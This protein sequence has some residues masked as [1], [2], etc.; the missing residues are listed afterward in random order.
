MV[1]LYQVADGKVESVQ[2]FPFANE[3][4]DMK[5]FIKDN[6]R[7]L[8]EIKI[9]ADEATPP[10]KSKRSDLLAVDKDGNIVILELKNSKVTS[11]VLSQVLQYRTY[12][13]KSVDTVKNFWND[14][15]AKHQSEIQPG[16]EW[17]SYDPKVIIVA[18][19]F[20]ED[21]LEVA[22]SNKL[23]IDFVEMRR[24]KRA[25][26]VF[27]TVDVKEIEEF[28]TTPTPGRKSEE[29]DWDHYQKMFG[30][31][32]VDLAKYYV[33]KI[34]QI[35]Q[36]KGWKLETHHKK[37]YVP[38][39]YESRNPFY[40]EQY[41]VGKI[42]IGVNLKDPMED[43]SSET[44]LK[45]GWNKNW[46]HWYIETDSKDLDINRISGILQKAYDITARV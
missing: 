3:I 45:W 12:W 38:F 26:S 30:T 5:R 1:D 18:S 7:L 20:D 8:G 25:D 43:P 40:L 15:A 19:S 21:L 28:A 14:Y 42:V 35:S 13:M 36:E 39:K 33:E 31:K 29:Y 4:D 11:D 10:S 22:K 32:W 23:E 16:P 24:Y 6:E 2:E 34:E 27:V 9:F 17:D 46:G 41:H 37:L 44:G